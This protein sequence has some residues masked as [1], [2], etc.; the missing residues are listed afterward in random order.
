[1]NSYYTIFAYFTVLKNLTVIS[2][3][4]DLSHFEY[5]CHTFLQTIL[6]LFLK[7]IQ[8]RIGHAPQP[9]ND[10]YLKLIAVNKSTAAHALHD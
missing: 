8:I 6:N 2:V 7:I 5:H 3:V 4:I 9:Q 1:M 10:S